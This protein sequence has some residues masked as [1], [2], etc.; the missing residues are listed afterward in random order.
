VSRVPPATCAV[1]RFLALPFPVRFQKYATWKAFWRV[2]VDGRKAAV[3]A[4]ELG[5]SPAAVYKHRE[6]VLRRLR[7]E[8]RGLLD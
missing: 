5:L 2:V 6:R 1:R 7:Q 8:L 4:A 3:V